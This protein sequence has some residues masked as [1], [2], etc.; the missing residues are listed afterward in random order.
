MSHDN[1]DGWWCDIGVDMDLSFGAGWMMVKFRG[2]EMENVPGGEIEEMYVIDLGAI[3]EANE[4]LE[5]SG[6]CWVKVTELNGKP[7]YGLRRVDDGEVV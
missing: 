2:V 7:V 4:F 1:D 6:W 3:R 5:N